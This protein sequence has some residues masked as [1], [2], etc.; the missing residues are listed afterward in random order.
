MKSPFLTDS[1]IVFARSVR[2]YRELLHASVV[3]S[4]TFPSQCA[5]ALTEL[6]LY[7]LQLPAVPPVEI[8]NQISRAWPDTSL[9]LSVFGPRALYR[10]VFDP[11]SDA[12]PVDCSLADDLAD[13]YRD[14]VSPLALFDSEDSLQAQGAVWEWRFTIFGHAGAHITSALRALHAILSDASSSETDGR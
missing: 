4:A 2:A 10:D 1:V 12:P 5:S 13:I 8:P 3:D 6:Y 11:F 9:L 7:G 14:L